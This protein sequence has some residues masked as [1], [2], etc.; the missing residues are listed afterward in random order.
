MVG[1]SVCKGHL[2]CCSVS[3]SG[4]LY[5]HSVSQYTRHTPAVRSAS[6]SQSSTAPLAREWGRILPLCFQNSALWNDSWN[7]PLT[8]PSAGRS[9]SRAWLSS[10]TIN[11][12]V[13]RQGLAFQLYR[14]SVGQRA[15]PG[16]PAVP[17]AGQ[18][19]SRAWP[20][21]CTISQSVSEQ[22]LA[23]QLY[24]QSVGQRAGLAFQL[25]RQSVSQRAG[26]G[27]SAVLPAS[28]SASWGSGCIFSCTLSGD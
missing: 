15:G 16:F 19:P 8:L 23:F 5:H 22:G 14:Q 11:Q 27:P 1:A 10:C 13:S 6:G 24:H 25:Y 9:A 3:P 7:D 26:P 12:S 20:S 4:R 18:S 17:P 2:S 21:S 28:Q